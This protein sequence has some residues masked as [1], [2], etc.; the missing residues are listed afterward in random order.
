[1]A[2]SGR[3]ELAG[4]ATQTATTTGASDSSDTARLGQTSGLQGLVV[5]AA[6]GNTP[7]YASGVITGDTSK[8]YAAAITISATSYS[9]SDLD[10][11]ALVNGLGTQTLTEVHAVYIAIATP[12]G[13]K[14]VRWGPMN[15]TNK[16]VG[17]FGAGTNAT[18]YQVVTEATLITNFLTGWAVSGTNKIIRLYNPGAGEITVHVWIMGK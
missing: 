13:T 14:S 9:S 5:T 12:D 2:F 18:D 16:W 17:P 15:Q 8:Q 3:L 10:L 11:E 6:N 4:D 7:G 1:M